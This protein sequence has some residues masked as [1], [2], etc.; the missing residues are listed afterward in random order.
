MRTIT[1]TLAYLTAFG[2]IGA[3]L[4]I[5]AYAGDIAVTIHNSIGGTL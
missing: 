1:A 4:W 5:L 2:A 3:V